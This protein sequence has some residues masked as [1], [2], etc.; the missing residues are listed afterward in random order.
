MLMIEFWLSSL[1]YEQINYVPQP[2]ERDNVSLSLKSHTG[3]NNFKSGSAI[4]L[5]WRAILY[6]AFT[7]TRTQA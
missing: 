4:F 3:K 2:F 7:K 6:L 5:S 1:Q